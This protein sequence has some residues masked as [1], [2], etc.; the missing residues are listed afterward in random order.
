MKTAL[1]WILYVTSKN[2]CTLFG[3]Y[4]FSAWIIALVCGDMSPVLCV[5]FIVAAALYKCMKNA[6]TYRYGKYPEIN[7][8]KDIKLLPEPYL[9]VIRIA[10][11]F[12]FSMCIMTA[13]VLP[14]LYA[15]ILHGD[16]ATAMSDRIGND[17]LAV[18]YSAL[19]TPLTFNTYNS[20]LVDS[21]DISVAKS[22]L[23]PQMIALEMIVL[24]ANI[25]IH[26]ITQF[27]A[28]QKK[29]IVMRAASSCL[30]V[31]GGVEDASNKVSS[32]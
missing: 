30:V 29:A 12:F 14:I 2:I 31:V 15:I 13:C 7:S 8:V 22:M 6:T 17:M 32:E 1:P 19:P 25:T 24:Y 18:A 9:F 11:P 5:I 21:N 28:E 10:E 16:Y 23:T 3:F 26:N 20:M 27:Y 4:I